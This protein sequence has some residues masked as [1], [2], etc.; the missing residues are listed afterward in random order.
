MCQPRIWRYGRRVSAPCRQPWVPVAETAEDAVLQVLMQLGRRLRER[1][2]DDL[3][4]PST[5]PLLFRLRCRGPERLSD[6]AAGLRLDAS[7]VSRHVRQLEDGGLLER[8]GDPA[9]G[10]ASVVALSAVGASLLAEA[11]RRRRDT[12]TQLL[13]DYDDSDREQLRAVLVQLAAAVQ[14]HSDSHQGPDRTLR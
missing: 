5:M 6:L 14:R 7:T 10:R 2:P 4:D 11:M 12:V 9:D 13:T 1:H 8:T 3:L